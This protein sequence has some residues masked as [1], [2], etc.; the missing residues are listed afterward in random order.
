[1]KGGE[2]GIGLGSFQR[3]LHSQVYV[4]LWR[5][6]INAVRFWYSLWIQM[7]SGAAYLLW[8][9]YGNQKV[10]KV[11][12][13]KALEVVLQNTLQ[14][15]Y[16]MV[17]P[18][19][20]YSTLHTALVGLYGSTFWAWYLREWEAWRELRSGI[21]NLRLWRCSEW[22]QRLA[23][24]WDTVFLSPKKTTILALC[25]DKALHG[26]SVFFIWLLS[27]WEGVLLCSSIALSSETPTI[28]LPFLFPHKQSKQ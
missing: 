14:G 19:G 22:E 3:S 12:K 7:L 6:N 24:L 8:L 20:C 4:I 1:M 28:E 23:S 11:F 10:C 18:F 21:W 15:W 25:W 26:H 9:V 17:A 2:E 27:A 13:G 16:S 5:W